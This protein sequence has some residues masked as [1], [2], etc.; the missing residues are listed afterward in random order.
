[1]DRRVF[2]QIPV[3]AFASTMIVKAQGLDPDNQKEDLK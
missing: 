3:L 1:M 2:L